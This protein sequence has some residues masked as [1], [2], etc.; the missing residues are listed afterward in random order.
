MPPPRPSSAMLSDFCKSEYDESSN[1]IR[2]V[3]SEVH[4][5]DSP[6]SVCTDMDIGN[7]GMDSDNDGSVIENALMSPGMFPAQMRKSRAR[8]IS[9]TQNGDCMSKRNSMSCRSLERLSRGPG[10]VSVWSEAAQIQ[11]PH[12]FRGAQSSQM[13]CTGC[14]FKSVVRYDKFDSITLT[15]PEI[16]RQG[17][18]LGHLLSEYVTS[19]TISDVECESCDRTCDHT[20]S[21]TFAKVYVK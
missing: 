21:L 11:I 18:S 8:T 6:H 7:D 16:R 17:L 3:R 13:I 9:S 14:G 20:K 2:Q 19:E 5:P 4:T 15:L 12:P 10:R 1:L